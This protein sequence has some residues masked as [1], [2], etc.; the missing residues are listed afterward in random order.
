MTFLLEE[1]AKHT[2]PEEVADKLQ[3]LNDT[4]EE[5]KTDDFEYM[6]TENV[7][8]GKGILEQA[9][10]DNVINYNPEIVEERMSKF[11]QRIA[12]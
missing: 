4:L 6:D 12:A 11:Q 9:M 7:S 1:Q 5:E 2:K 10:E 8:A 3:E